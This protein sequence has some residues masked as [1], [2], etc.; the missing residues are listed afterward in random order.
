MF[1]YIMNGVMHREMLESC[2]L[3]SAFVHCSFK[4][5]QVPTC[6]SKGERRLKWIFEKYTPD[7]SR[8][9]NLLSL[10]MGTSAAFKKLLDDKDANHD[11]VSTTTM[12]KVSGGLANFDKKQMEQGVM[13]YV[14]TLRHSC[15]FL[16]CL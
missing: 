12:S 9:V 16:I 7:V 14:G 13:A 5:Y 8:S 10:P 4:Q 1:T 15:L 3:H 6:S 11:Q 2:R